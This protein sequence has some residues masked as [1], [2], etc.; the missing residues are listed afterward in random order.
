VGAVFLMLIIVLLLE[1]NLSVIGLR[2]DTIR[3][4]IKKGVGW[5][6]VSGGL[7]ALVSIPVYFIF[8]VN[9]LH[10]I[11]APLPSGASKLLTFFIT[12]A[13]LSPV[14]EELFFRGILYTYF[15]K[16]GV[17]V[18]FFIS[19]A[20]FVC[21]HTGGTGLPYIQLIGG[22]LFALAFEF[23][24]NLMVPIVIHA[25]GNLFIFSVAFARGLSVGY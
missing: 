18:A 3:D 25:G 23:N 4:G 21:L 1:K 10:F 20:L 7:A 11:S 12:G 22:V 15:R 19:T 14:A 9:C 5:A 24:K 8:S 16:W 17:L 13:I 2:V 6:A